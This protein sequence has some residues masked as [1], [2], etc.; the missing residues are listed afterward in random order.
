MSDLSERS[1]RHENC[2]YLPLL[3]LSRER[4]R[5]TDWV[6]ACVGTGSWVHR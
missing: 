1:R 5:D 4:E 6:C 2:T 3:D